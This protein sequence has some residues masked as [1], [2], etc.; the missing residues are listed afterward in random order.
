MLKYKGGLGFLDIEIF[1]LAL[2]ARQAWRILV[3]PN[4]LS[5]RILKAIYFPTTDMLQAEVGSSP[6]QI[7]R[8][9][10]EGRDML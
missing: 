9:L 4:S 6:S 10:C 8:S 5:A 1:N 2:L 7:W 3:E